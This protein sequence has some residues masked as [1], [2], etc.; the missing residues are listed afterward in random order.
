MNSIIDASRDEGISLVEV[1]VA[2]IILGLAMV[3]ILGGFSVSVRGG[4]L[5]GKQAKAETVLRSAAE[6]VVAQGFKKCSGGSLPGYSVTPSVDGLTVAVTGFAY[7]TGSNPATFSSNCSQ[8]ANGI[9]RVSL[10][11]TSPGNPVV[12]EEMEVF[13]GTTL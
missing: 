5:Y 9:G 4:V 2:T 6:N 11:V 1:L 13:V 10:R 12:V 8:D 3:A 7:W